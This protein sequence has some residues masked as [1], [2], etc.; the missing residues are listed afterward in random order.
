MNGNADTS[1]T[2][3]SEVNEDG[4]EDQITKGNSGAIND[5]NYV[6]SIQ[7][8]VEGNENDNEDHSTTDDNEDCDHDLSQ[9]L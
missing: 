6:Q 9:Y 7:G 5:K 4:N 3:K 8:E 1:L 2:E